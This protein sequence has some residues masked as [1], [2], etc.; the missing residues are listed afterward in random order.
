MLSIG[1]I[2]YVYIVHNAYT[3][4]IIPLQ[5]IDMI[6]T[7]LNILLHIYTHIYLYIQGSNWYNAEAALRPCIYTSNDNNIVD[8]T[9]AFQTIIGILCCLYSIIIALCVYYNNAMT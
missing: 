3:F 4:F 7:M 5:Y 6:F 2:M 8:P 1:Y 9:Q